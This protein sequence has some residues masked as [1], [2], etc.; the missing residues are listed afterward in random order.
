M[1]MQENI[2]SLLTHWSYVFLDRYELI[3]FNN[4][5]WSQFGVGIC[6]QQYIWRQNGVYTH[7]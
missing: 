3:N 7:G 4:T 1:L 5:K 2:T 6:E